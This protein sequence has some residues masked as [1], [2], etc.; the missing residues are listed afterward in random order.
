MRGFQQP[1]ASPWNTRIPSFF[2]AALVALALC[3]IAPQARAAIFRCIGADGSTT[4]SDHA[5]EPLKGSDAPALNGPP[6]KGGPDSDAY[7]HRPDN[8]RE[9]KAAHI[10]DVLRISPVEPEAMLLR[11]TVDDAA[12]DLVQSLDP[13]NPLWTPANYRWHAVSEFVKSDLRRDVQTAL[14]SSTAQVAQVTA[15][16]YAA[17]A[18]DA[19][20]E[21]LSAFL[22][23]PEG[24]RYL[25][26]QNEVRPLLY[27]V[28]SSLQAQE[29]MP[30][31]APSEREMAQRRQLLLLTLEYRIAQS[32][33]PPLASSELQPGSKTVLENAIRREGATLD[34]LFAEYEPYLSSFQ[35]FTDSTTAKR[36]FVAVEPALRTELALSSTAATD[37]AELEFDRYFQRWHGYYG[38]M[39]VSTRTTVLIRGRTVLMSHAVTTRVLPGIQSAEAMAIQCEERES[40]MYRGLH[41][42]A[43]YNSQA[44]ELRQIQNRCRA[45]QRLPPIK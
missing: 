10:L 20:M 44:A 26:F 8:P 43:D 6:T 28:L 41:R 31:A 36:L 18:D 19:D 22:K 21:A 2:G 45:E 11:R 12:P 17:R 33:A 5:C 35:T 32:A 38:P 7:A 25:A 29:P 39:R 3:V 13:D 42:S 24:T 23:T 9:K 14:R 34:T 37:F 16:Q 15:R 40:S 1:A 27:A 30:E 4:F